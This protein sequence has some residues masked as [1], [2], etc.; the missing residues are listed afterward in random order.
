MSEAPVS[1]YR[2]QLRREFGFADVAGIA[3]Y[4]ADLGVTHVY[5]SPI[6]QAAP[7]SA[8]GYDVV[9]HTRIS[10]ELGGEDGFRAMAARLH[11][12][13]LRIV[14][15]I[16]PNH[17]ALPA[18]EDLS[19]VLWPVLSEGRGSPY[20]RWLDV[21]WEAG[22]GRIV[23]PVLGGPPEEVR[24]ELVED[25]DVLRYHDHVFPL[26]GDHYR[27]AYWR[28]GPNYRRFFE[29][30]TLAG[31]RVEDPEVF[32]RTHEVILRLVREGL[33]DGLRVDHPDGLAAPRAYLSRLTDE[34]R[35]MWTVVEKILTGPEELAPDWPCAGT[36]GYDALNMVGGVFVD[37]AAEGPLTEAYLAFTGGPGDF[38]EVAHQAKRQMAEHGL[39]PEVDRLHRALQAALPS[40]DPDQMRRALVELLVAMPV[41]RVYVEPGEEML[42]HTR[43]VVAEAVQAARRRLPEDLHP[44]LDTIAPVVSGEAGCSDLAAEVAVRF[45]QTAAPLM[46]KG[47]ED[48]AFYRWSRLAAR[49]E[50]GGEPERFAVT[51]AEFHEF[52]ARLAR[53]WPFTMTTLSTHDTK[54][55]EDVRARL[56]ALAELD[57]E[58]TA[59]VGRWRAPD[60]PLEPDLEYLLW[61]TVVG[62]WPLAPERLAEYLTKAM[63]EAKTRTSW[64]DPDPAYEEAVLAY[65][66]E[67]VPEEDVTAFVALMEPY[68][69]AN[70]LGQKLVQLAMPGVADVYQGCELVGLSLVDPDNRRPVDYGERR[71]RLA[72]LDAGESP[73]DLDD[74]KLLVTSRTLRLRRRHPEWFGPDL[75]EPVEATGPAAGHALAFRR[76][77][78][79]A[80]ATRLPAGLEAHGGWRDTA[81]D[82]P[83]GPWRDVITGAVHEDTALERVLSHLPVALLVQGDA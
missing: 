31:L 46:A 39:R 38:A 45:Q 71:R 42:P 79:V 25:G 8:H 4:L 75:Y 67:C 3:G 17:M 36:T 5:L 37:P 14:V 54:R 66:R 1:T 77:G 11:E 18:P 60:S 16:V 78:A 68:A 48:T 61:Q 74:E 23:L 15:D 64:T 50:V 43:R 82:L 7:G 19:P 63:R 62:A 56:A 24:D 28:E 70:M 72:R 53:D 29:I 41:Y 76:G 35:G 80:V 57:E 69:R 83:K 13:G 6:L 47:V 21:D 22:D 73:R 52:C 30:S 10:E 12:A 27:L 32:D 58:W 81:L 51:P 34:T 40:H 44:V 49:N 2:V 59:A 26:P 55:Q 20:A 33:I 9:D 65:A